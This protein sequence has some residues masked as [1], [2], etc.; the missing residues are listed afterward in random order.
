ME[1]LDYLRLA[2][3]R[4]WVLVGVPVAAT[5]IATAIVLSAPQQYAGTA[6][7]A[8][9]ALVG[10]AAAQQFTGQQA[11]NQFVAAFS[12]AV[13]SPKVIDQVATD[14][15]VAAGDL[16][17]GLKVVQVGA[18][19]QLEIRYTATQRDTVTPVLSAASRRAL[20]FLFSSQVDI[21]TQEVEAASA[22]VTAATKAIG[23][24]EKTHK[25]S[26]PDKLYQ[27][28]LSELASLRQQQLNMQAVGNGR[29]VAAVTD[30]IAAA[31]KR[32]DEIGPKLP[33]YQ[34]LIAQR[35]A[36][37]ST[38][39]QARQGLQSARAQ[40]QAADPE[41]VTSVGE[42]DRVSRSTVLLRTA[43]PVA[44]AGVL[45]AVVLVA[46]LEL[47]SRVRAARR[48]PAGSGAPGTPGTGADAT[49]LVLPAVPREETDSRRGGMNRGVGGPADRSYRQVNVAMVGGESERPG[50]VVR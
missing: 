8:A 24:W 1:I 13:T 20:T 10:G 27:A 47:L 23:D 26:Q 7:V 14:T 2:R 5:G 15:G 9:P 12:A 28:T 37:T 21:A 35:D 32:L 17:D 38:L 25:V 30:A 44:G 48:K 34:V 29:A 33:D 40:I 4:L 3:R 41:Q 16:R 46:F 50:R 22:D 39:A 42:V 18:S 49:T 31:Q 11:A 19:S 43:L 36:A 6:Y 45:I